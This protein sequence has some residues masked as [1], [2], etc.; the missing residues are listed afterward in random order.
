MYATIIK[1]IDRNSGL[2]DQLIRYFCVGGISAG[3]DWI[4]FY[5]LNVTCGIYYMFAATGSFLLSVVVNFFWGR[6]L[7]FKNRCKFTSKVEAL[8]I[9]GINTMGLIWN[10][11]LMW[12][13]IEMVK[14]T[15]MEAKI[16]A[17]GIVFLWNFSLRR[18]WLYKQTVTKSP[19]S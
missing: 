2:I 3:V 1:T 5:I 9:L 6:K 4:I 8:N 12:L 18:W 10:I 16:G 17:T 11:L 14:L 15:T 7:A 19:H 13:A